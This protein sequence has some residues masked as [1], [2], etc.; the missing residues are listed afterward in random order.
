[1]LK[2]I[3]IAHRGNGPPPKQWLPQSPVSKKDAGTAEHKKRECRWSRRRV[4]KIVNENRPGRF[5]GDQ[6]EGKCQEK[7]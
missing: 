4:G 3:A 6:A 7:S 5:G 1:M 2:M